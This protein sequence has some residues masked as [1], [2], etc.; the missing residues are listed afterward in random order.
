MKKDRYIVL[1]EDQQTNSLKKV[2]KE[3]EVSITSSEYLSKENRSYEVIDEDN[4]VLY[5]NLGVLVVENMDEAQLKSAVRNDSNPIVYFEKEKEFFPADELALINELKKQSVEL[6]D[7]ITELEK[8]IINKPLPQKSLVEMEWGLKA[9]GLGNALYTGKGVDICILDTGLETS[10]PDFLSR[11]IEGKSFI[12]GEDWNRDPNGH[13]THCA[14]VVSGNIRSDNG[15][16]Y[17]IAKDCNLKIAKVLSD[18]GKG[19][20]SS[21][22]DAIDWA[23]T[24]KFRILSLSLASPVKLNE[25]P[26]LLFETVGARALENNCLIIAA[27]GNDSSRPSIPLP[28]SSPANAQSIMA[29]AAIDGQMK[30]AKFSNAGLNPTTGGS[31]NVCAPGVDIISS[32]PKNTKNKTS[33]YYAMSGTSMAT[34]HVSA[35]AALYV[36]QFPNKSAKEIWE[37]I[38]TKAKPI[39]GI[40][41]RDIGSGLIQV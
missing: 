7:K 35:L 38:E 9:I 25:T 27:A 33:N 21:V 31:V 41:Y 11:D 37:L 23:I 29:V 18:N 26:S 8:Y 5:K 15:K 22:I 40:K 3:L 14:G 4:G 36:E 2:E 39:E 13:G 30:I 10:H 17:G 24:K 16:R 12:D 19:T 32:Y 34:P 28:V 20:T 1:L 6:A